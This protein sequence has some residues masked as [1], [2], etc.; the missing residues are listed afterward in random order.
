L[1]I[2]YKSIEFQSFTRKILIYDDENKVYSEIILMCYGRGT[3]CTN[4]PYVYAVS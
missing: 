2:L 3:Y 1:A 4:M